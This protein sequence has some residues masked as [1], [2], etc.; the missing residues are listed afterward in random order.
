MLST[1]HIAPG[2]NGDYLNVLK[3]DLLPVQK[4]GQV[5]RFTVSQVIVG[6]DPNE[7]RTATYMDDFAGL[8]AGPAAV[9]VRP[10]CGGTIDSR[11]AWRLDGSSCSRD[12][13]P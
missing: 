10:F 6:G 11:S 5:K 12:C 4:K 2:R 8:D 1:N 9:R 7:Y 3:N 13:Q